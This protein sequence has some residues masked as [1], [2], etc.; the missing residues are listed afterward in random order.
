MHP[1]E[2]VRDGASTIASTG[3]ACA[4]RNSQSLRGLSL[5]NLSNDDVAAGLKTETKFF[6]F[7]VWSFSSSG[8][9]VT[10]L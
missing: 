6:E 5:R 1:D 10:E 2:K 4:P 3:A 9:T 8:L 7:Q